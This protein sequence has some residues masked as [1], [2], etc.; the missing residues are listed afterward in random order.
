MNSTFT[1][2]KFVLLNYYHSKHL[3]FA[4]K[5]IEFYII[6]LNNLHNINMCNILR[7]INK[8]ISC[9]NIQHIFLK[10]CHN[11]YSVHMKYVH[12]ILYS[13]QIKCILCKY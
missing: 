3:A 1:N 11:I 4:M 10:V 5:I 8:L 9:D 12:N 7:H 6:L 2:L 13:E